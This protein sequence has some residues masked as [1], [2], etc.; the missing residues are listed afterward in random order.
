MR[1]VL[2]LLLL[3]LISSCSLAEFM[4]PRDSTTTPS[5]T[6]YAVVRPVDGFPGFVEGMVSIDGVITLVSDEVCMLVSAQSLWQ[7]GDYWDADSDAPEIEIL[8]DTVIVIPDTIYAVG[9]TVVI[10]DDD[11]NYVG[12]YPLQFRYCSTFEFASGD[13]ALTITLR[14]SSDVMFQYEWE[15]RV[16]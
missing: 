1:T 9:P 8:V 13:Y 3:L 10:S 7:A 12:A 15:F 6:G 2:L 14:T 5:Y 4:T 16:P 11:G